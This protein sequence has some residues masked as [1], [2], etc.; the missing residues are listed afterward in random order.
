M[1]E[2]ITFLIP[3]RLVALQVL[4]V[5]LKLRLLNS[6]KITNPYRFFTNT[7]ILIVM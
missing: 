1:T 3:K 5:S 2:R 4:T 6:M 7:S